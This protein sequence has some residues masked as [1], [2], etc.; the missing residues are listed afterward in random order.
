[1]DRHIGNKATKYRLSGTNK[2]YVNRQA[3]KKNKKKAF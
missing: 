3:N 2:S 1:M